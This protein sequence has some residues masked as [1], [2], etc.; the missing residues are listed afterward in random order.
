M[1][2]LNMRLPFSLGFAL[3]L[4]AGTMAEAQDKQPVSSI[5]GKPEK[6]DSRFEV[7]AAFGYSLSETSFSGTQTIKDYVEEGTLRSSYDVGKA[8]GLA[9]D[10][11]YNL[12]KKFGVR[13]GIQTF[14][15]KS[16]GTFDASVPHPF[17]F[18]RPRS[19][20]GS[21]G[22]LDFKESAISLTAVYRGGSGKWKLNAE[23]GP[24]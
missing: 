6:G 20:S 13:A 17:F 23:A 12:T 4:A 2:S 19:V 18:G 11:Q 24:Q 3:A 22:D 7:G 1:K 5:T 16:H 9:F 15:R 8:P 10:L 21:Q 14:T